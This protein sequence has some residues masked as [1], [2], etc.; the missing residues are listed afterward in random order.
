VAFLPEPP[1]TSLS[2]RAQLGLVAGITAVAMVVFALTVG[3]LGAMAG[4]VALAPAMAAGRLWGLRRGLLWSALACG[5]MNG[6]MWGA[7]QAPWSASE[8]AL[9]IATLLGAGGLTG[10]LQD[11]RTEVARTERE[12]VMA[13]TRAHLATSERLASLG[14]LAASIAHEINNPMAFI[15]SNLDF[16]QETLTEPNADLG[17]LRAAIEEARQGARRVL[18]I[19]TDMRKLSRG[20][21]EALGPVDV[22]TAIQSALNLA[23]AAMKH[24]V[25]LK[26]ELGE[27][28]PV[29][30]TEA[31]LGQV[32][33]NLVVNATQA[34]PQR[35]ASSNRILVASRTDEQGR[36]VIEV[37]DN[38]SGI[39]K[40]VAARVFDP[41]FTTKPP[42]VGTG[43][44][45]AICHSI[46]T[47]LGGELSFVTAVGEGTTFR[48]VLP[49]APLASLAS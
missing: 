44:G 12:R 16:A 43:L 7:G 28:P 24:S 30:A 25:T 18:G 29:L 34:M 4:A 8:L 46:V 11:L 3:R 47:A 37:H 13:E 32:V 45:L 20:T 9:G 41:F 17:E 35:L 14:T 23:G 5:L 19:V 22:P 39:P 2:T 31:R 26:V 21:D 42:G 49:P 1:R 6:I 36:A 40:E 33:M 10:R 15:L 27:V 48:V 38:G